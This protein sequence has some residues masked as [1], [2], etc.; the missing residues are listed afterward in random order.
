M[1]NESNNV[2]NSLKNSLNNIKGLIEIANS[3][4]QTV[5]LLSNSLIELIENINKTK[6]VTDVIK[7]IADQTNL[8]ALN[9]AI[10]AARAGEHGRG[11]AVVADEVRKLAEN[12][13][14]NADNITSHMNLLSNIV[15]DVSKNVDTNNINADDIQSK[16]NLLQNTILD[17]ENNT[18]LLIEDSKKTAKAIEHAFSELDEI[19]TYLQDI[20]NK[21][22]DSLKETKEITNFVKTLNERLHNVHQKIEELKTT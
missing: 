20:K 21:S 13:S 15:N 8:L 19:V 16:T 18:D 6:E 1:N 7:E 3:N 9:A 5:S 12:V 17:L 11:F 2:K 10:E 14:K 4:T 22:N